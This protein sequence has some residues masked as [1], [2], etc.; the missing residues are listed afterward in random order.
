LSLLDSFPLLLPECELAGL[1]EINMK[2]RILRYFGQ[3]ENSWRYAL[4]YDYGMHSRHLRGV[5]FGNE[6]LIIKDGDLVIKAGYAW[7][8]C[9]PCVSIL[10]L[11]YAGPPDGAQLVGNPATYHASLVHDALCQ[12]R[13][14][15]P[16]SKAISVAV[17]REL[18]DEA[19]FPLARVYATAVAL[20]GP[21]MFLLDSS[22][23]QRIEASKRQRS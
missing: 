9:S 8:G 13:D 12:F 21:Q 6:W 16:I 1:R 20:F 15:V 22:L 3:P 2:H 23:P 18:L 5:R 11:F 19:R 4:S 10:G 7:D 14:E 17:F